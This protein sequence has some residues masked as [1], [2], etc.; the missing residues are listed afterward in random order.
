M[1]DT[2]KVAT[3]FV[4]HAIQEWGDPP[5]K[6]IV[7]VQDVLDKARFKATATCWPVFGGI[8]RYSCRGVDGTAATNWLQKLTD[9]MPRGHFEHEVAHVVKCIQEAQNG[10][11]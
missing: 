3:G 4:L 2:E 8:W 11:R 5:E 9:T 1:M 6:R 7:A 10:P